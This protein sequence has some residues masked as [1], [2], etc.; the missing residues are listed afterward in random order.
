MNPQ[1]GGWCSGQGGRV[2]SPHFSVLRIFI[3]F[4]IGQ[5]KKHSINVEFRKSCG[6]SSYS[7][8]SH[9]LP[10]ETLWPSSDSRRPERG[11]LRGAEASDA[12]FALTL[13]SGATV[14]V[15]KDP[16]KHDERACLFTPKSS[17]CAKVPHYQM[18]P[19]HVRPA[20]FLSR[21]IIFK[22]D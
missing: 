4:Y 21:E 19:L 7:D 17:I 15:I 20:A 9:H 12:S 8:S 13:W 11:L 16:G 3:P 14:P 22:K 10:S 1:R 6:L 5:I 2:C 18:Y